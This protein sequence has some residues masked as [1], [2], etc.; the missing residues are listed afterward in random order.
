MRPNLIAPQLSIMGKEITARAWNIQLTPNS[1]RKTHVSL[2]TKLT[3][4]ASSKNKLCKIGPQR[5]SW[6]FLFRARGEKL[7]AFRSRVRG[8]VKDAAARKLTK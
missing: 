2:A 1:T 6:G 5:R 8:D 7:A 3:K 4:K